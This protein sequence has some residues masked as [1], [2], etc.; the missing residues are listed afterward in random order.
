LGNLK[1]DDLVYA[2]VVLDYRNE[3]ETGSNTDLWR[4]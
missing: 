1:N 2:R 4:F 3:F